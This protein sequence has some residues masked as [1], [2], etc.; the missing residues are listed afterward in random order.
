LDSSEK[1]TL[2][3]PIRCA[4]RFRAGAL[5]LKLHEDWGTTPSAIDQCL[6]VAEEFDVQVAITH[7]HP[8]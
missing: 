2:R 1:E 8:E 6:T 7:R 4:S 5:G 3:F